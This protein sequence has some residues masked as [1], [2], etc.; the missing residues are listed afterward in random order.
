MSKSQMFG[1]SFLVLG[2]GQFVHLVLA[3]QVREYDRF[4]RVNRCLVATA[5][6]LMGVGDLAPPDAVSR[7]MMRSLPLV[8]L[9]AGVMGMSVRRLMRR[10][11]VRG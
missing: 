7:A 9:V 3:E 8:L 4:E 5:I 10:R 1:V 2:L 6:V 11:N